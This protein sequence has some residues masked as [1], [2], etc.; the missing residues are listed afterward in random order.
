MRTPCPCVI[1]CLVG[2]ALLAGC[3]REKREFRAPPVQT[4]QELQITSVQAGGTSPPARPPAGYD[5]NAYAMSQGQQLYSDF[6]CVGCHAYGGGDIGPPLLDDKW[7][8]GSTPPQI[9]ASIVQGRPNG[10]PAFGPRIAGDQVW[11]IVAYVRSLSGLASQT[12]AP[13][14]DDHI[15][16]GPPPNSVD[17]QKPVNLSEPAPR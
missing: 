4:G 1:G 13:G 9:Y 11:Q 15:K 8:Y 5:G 12:A 2:A 10:M 6:N 17:P 7:I 3:E 16:T 14:R